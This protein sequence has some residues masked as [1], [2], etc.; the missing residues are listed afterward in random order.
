MDI[1]DE[2]MQ[3]LK[4][5]SIAQSWETLRAALERAAGH[6]PIA[7]DF[8]VRACLAVAGRLEDVTPAVAAVTCTHMGLILVD[9]ILDDDPRGAYGELGAGRA[10]NL[11]A[12]LFSL[13]FD[14]VLTSANPAR[15]VAAGVLARLIL[16]T[17]FGQDLDVQNQLSEEAYWQAT[18]TKSSPYFGAALSVGAWMAGAE[19]TVA[20]QL[21]QF[22]ELFG[23]IMQIHDDLNDC[24]AVPANVDWAQGRAPLPILFALLAPHPAR[25][26]FE[27]IRNQV[28]D[29]ALLEEAQAILV[30]SGA[31]SYCV[32]EL[33]LRHEEAERLLE[34]IPLVDHQPLSQLLDQVIA[35][36]NHLFAQVGVA[37]A[38]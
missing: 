16:R 5:N 31:I 27:E 32:N 8:P 4:Q 18:R 13:G 9:D 7:W 2:A 33:R 38:A 26:R 17:A 15:H 28:S 10:A 1:Y 35:P 34:K 21:Q 30:S 19:Q 22:G 14:A 36:V 20:E 37:G 3:L 25:Q 11:S 24:L 6:K 12:G 23:E 29:P